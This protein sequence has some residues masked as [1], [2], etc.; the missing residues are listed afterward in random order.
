[1]LQLLG[2]EAFAETSPL[3]HDSHMRNQVVTPVL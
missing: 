2:P 1:M 3:Y